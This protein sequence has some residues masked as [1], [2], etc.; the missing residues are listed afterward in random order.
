[1]HLVYRFHGRFAADR[2]LAPLVSDY[3][4]SASAVSCVFKLLACNSSR[5]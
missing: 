5:V 2:S 1:L 4:T 3:T